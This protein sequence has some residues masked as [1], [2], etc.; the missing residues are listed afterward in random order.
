VTL[1][2]AIS[3]PGGDLTEPV[4]RHTQR[5]AQCFW[6][7]DKSL[8]EARMFPAISLRNSYSQIS[9]AVVDWWTSATG[10]DWATL[11]QQA[12]AMLNDAARAEATARLV[13]ADTLPE[14]Q[15]WLLVAARLFEDGFLR[16][17]AF[18]RI[19]AYCSPARQHRLLAVLL[20][21]YRRGV[22]AIER[23]STTRRLSELPI[24]PR[25]VRA[26][27]EIGDDALA[28]FDQLHQAIDAECAA[29][30]RALADTAT[31]GVAG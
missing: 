12:L 16:Q 2:S 13:G 27:S 15:Q 14:P 22:A 24:M 28:A 23:G 25:L 30:E 17:N 21:M 1:I 9:P 26:R 4:T 5:F 20:H 10:G 29:I 7:L 31:A 8:A 3:P 19:D 18:D 6:T 11:R